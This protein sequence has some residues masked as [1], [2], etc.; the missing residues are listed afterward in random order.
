MH[1]R[2]EYVHTAIRLEYFTVG[3]NILEGIAA[4]VLGGV[5]NSVA[6]IGF[7]LDSFVETF[8]GFVVLRRFRAEA[9]GHCAE[10]AEAKALKYVAWSF[11]I[12]AAYIAIDSGHKLLTAE[13]PDPSVPGIVLAALSL[14]IMPLLAYRKRRAGQR[15]VSTALVSDSK[16]TVVCAFLSVFLLAG[17]MF[18]AAFG[19]WWADPIGALA[20]L[21]W[22]IRE[23]R[24]ALLGRACCD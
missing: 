13:R 22:L 8:S 15:L 20:M 9:A 24:E 18:N 2:Q 1:T 5:A 16:Q 7:G 6:L 3:Y 21:P 14:V 19:W 10:E 23:G 12:L 4:L 11:F 17:L